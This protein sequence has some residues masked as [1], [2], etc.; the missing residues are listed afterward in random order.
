MS[1]Y[2]IRFVN[3]T[4]SEKKNNYRLKV[5][6][7]ITD[8]AGNFKDVSSNRVTDKKLNIDVSQIIVLAEFPLTLVC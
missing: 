6:I 3:L 4:V 2:S 5:D 8:V 1:E 7:E